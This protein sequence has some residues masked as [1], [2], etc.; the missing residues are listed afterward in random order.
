[1]IKF[2]IYFDMFTGYFGLTPVSL[3]WRYCVVWQVPWC[4]VM[5]GRGQAEGVRLHPCPCSVKDESNTE[6]RNFVYV[7]NYQL[8]IDEKFTVRHRV[9]NIRTL[10]LLLCIGSTLVV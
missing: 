4:S 1:M 9:T 8:F 2:D 5:V 3:V 6:Y 10:L 7:K